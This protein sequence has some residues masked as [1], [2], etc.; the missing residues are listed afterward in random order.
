MPLRSWLLVSGAEVMPNLPQGSVPLNIQ[1][2]TRVAPTHCCSGSGDILG[3][4]GHKVGGLGCASLG[5]APLQHKA[6]LSITGHQQD[7]VPKP[8]EGVGE[9]IQG[10][11]MRVSKSTG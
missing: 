7:K 11:D 6:C 5:C 4:E 10:G 2:D 9:S 8:I 1:T 3:S